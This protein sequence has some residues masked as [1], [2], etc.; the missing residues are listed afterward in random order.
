MN[1]INFVKETIKEAYIVVI[2]AVIGIASFL[3]A[4]LIAYPA[5][6]YLGAK[7]FS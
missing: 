6:A 3:T 2:I 4:I 1:A 7:L 5:L